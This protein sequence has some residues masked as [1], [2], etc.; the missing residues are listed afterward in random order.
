MSKSNNMRIKGM[1]IQI[2]A[3]T[4]GLAK[5]LNSANRGISSAK[6]SISELNKALKFDPGN[7]DLLK[8]RTAAYGRAV[9][10]AKKK[11]DTLKATLQT[12]LSNGSF[13]KDSQEATILQEEIDKANSSLKSLQSTYQELNDNGGHTAKELAAAQEDVNKSLKDTSSAADDAAQH[14]DS[15]LSL[16]KV[17]DFGDALT[18]N[19]TKPLV[20]FAKTGISGAIDYESSLA[21]IKTLGVASDQLDKIDDQVKQVSDD[22]GASMKNISEATYQAISGGRDPDEAVGFVENAVKTAKAGMAETSDVVDLIDAIINKYGSAA[23]TAEEI[24]DKLLVTQNKGVTNVAKLSQSLGDIIPTAESAGIS[25]D[26]LL[27]TVAALTKG[28][29]DTSKATTGLKAALSNIIN[30]SKE[31]QEAAK[32]LNIDFSAQALS[33]KGLSGFLSDIQSKMEA[34]SPAYA[35]VSQSVDQ[36][37]K[38]LS[39]NNGTL[40]K[41]EEQVE[42]LTAKNKDL[43]KQM[44][45]LVNPKTGK[46]DTSSE[47]YK[48]LKAQYDANKDQINSIKDQNKTLKASNTDL[49]KSLSDQQT[50]LETLANATKS[51]IQAYATLFGSVEGLNAVMSLTSETG[52]K[53]LQNIQKDMAGSAGQL[54]KAYKDVEDTTGSRLEKA[55]TALQ[56]FQ[57]NLAEELLPTI[58]DLLDDGKEVLNF[59]NNMP[60]GMKKVTVGALA[61]SAALGPLVSFGAS[62]GQVGSALKKLGGASSVLDKFK[63]FKGTSTTTTTAKP[64]TGNVLGDA[65]TEVTKSTSALD[66]LKGVGVKFVDMSSYVAVAAEIGLVVKEYAKVASDISQ[67]KFT[68]DYDTN[69]KAT[70]K[71]AGSMAAFEAGMTAVMTK[72]QSSGNGLNMLAGEGLSAAF[73]A[74]LGE[75]AIVIRAYAN[76]IQSISDLNIGDD[77]QTNLDAVIGMMATAGIFTGGVAGLVTAIIGT[78]GGAGGLAILAGEGVVGIAEAELAYAAQI[79]Q[80]YAATVQQIN[81]LQIDDVT[82]EANMTKIQDTM[83]A[84]NGTL[85]S[86]GFKAFFTAPAL[87]AGSLE[88][89][90]AFLEIKELIAIM[91]TLSTTPLPDAGQLDAFRDA[92]GQMKAIVSDGDTSLFGIF[93]SL[94]SAIQSGLDTSTTKNVHDQF[95]LMLDMING[96][97]GLS[98]DTGKGGGTLAQAW[99]T[100]LTM[101]QSDT[102]QYM[103]NIA[104]IISDAIS[105]FEKQFKNADLSFNKDIV[106]PHFSMRGQF[107]AKDGSVPSV[108]VS[109]YKKGGI[110]SSPSV[111]GVGDAKSPEAV[112]PIDKLQGMLATTSGQQ[113]QQIVSILSQILAA[114]QKPVLLDGKT[115]VGGIAGEMDNALGQR[116]ERSRRQR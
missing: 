5:A 21:N 93:E 4:S 114:Q 9:D 103:S 72:V 58:N 31:A 18:N 32:S 51:P 66:A 78:T 76:T 50:Q 15:M 38:E 8:D 45:A 83:S 107:D 22:T 59:L 46:K 92:M 26:E 106:L 74:E 71:L 44:D 61:L 56:N 91:N 104:K 37:N 42:S 87:V 94:G 89:A 36:L 14:M 29:M 82:L 88:N 12:G 57:I 1:T 96:L 77:Y 55:Q 47:T 111:I 99:S 84:M 53:D 16:D 70:L 86:E 28:G 110:F 62:V 85:A 19:V 108:D 3:D 68:E 101:V 95:M 10:E 34:A 100:S 27:S 35:Q 13:T 23:G 30:P 69:L 24:S 115:L 33:E 64:G 90:A 102:Q 105:G 79:I 97:K 73:T 49:K 81:D 25:L 11:V 109:W 112:V 75:A 63:G 20:N 52:A 2:G 54:T 43:K 39:S 67:Y 6:Q 7:V 80:S 98:G 116:T 17:K 48:N 113:T 40:S 65:V 60:E 41:N